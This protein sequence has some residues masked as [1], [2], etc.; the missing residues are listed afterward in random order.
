M[1]T[2]AEQTLVPHFFLEDAK[3][4]K[5]SD[6]EN[7]TT[8]NI[9][10]TKNE[11]KL[12][13]FILGLVESE[14]E[15]FETCDSGNGSEETDIPRK[16]DDEA[17]DSEQSDDVSGRPSKVIMRSVISDIFDGQIESSE[18]GRAHV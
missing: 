2:L 6:N 13:N 15:S 11:T 8:N 1:D 18:I 16:R 7:G 9:T 10:Q 3:P 5:E 17:V 4:A 14:T 12:M